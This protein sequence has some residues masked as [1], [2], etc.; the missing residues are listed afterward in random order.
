MSF[1]IKWGNNVDDNDS[2]QSL[3][4]QSLK[5]SCDNTLKTQF[6]FVFNVVTGRNWVSL[7]CW[8]WTQHAGGPHGNTPCQAQWPALG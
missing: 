6:K 8:P 7:L 3:R 2:T 5:V 4:N 1:H